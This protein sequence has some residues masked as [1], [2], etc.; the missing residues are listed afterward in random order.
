M[1]GGITER[2]S[3]AFFH[4]RQIQLIGKVDSVGNTG[5][6]HNQIR[7]GAFCGPQ[8]SVLA[9]SNLLKVLFNTK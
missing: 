1:C 3:E 5:A 2:Y 9:F 8:I 6:T 7:H 4:Q